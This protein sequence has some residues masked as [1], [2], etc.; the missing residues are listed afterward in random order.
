MV[1]ERAGKNERGI[2]QRGFRR[3]SAAVPAAGFRSVPL[4]GYKRRLE[5][6][7]ET[8]PEPAGEDA[9]ATIFSGEDGGG[10]KLRPPFGVDSLFADFCCGV[11]QKLK[12][13]AGESGGNYR[14]S[15]A[16]GHCRAARGDCAAAT[17]DFS[18]VCGHCLNV[19]GDCLAVSGNCLKVNAGCL[20]VSG[21]G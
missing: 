6:R 2:F 15:K 7:G 3:R 8:P 4:R 1:G 12:V 16:S 13:F 14:K 19:R 18:N 10:V 20:G 9:R 5:S 21:I 11:A 17:V